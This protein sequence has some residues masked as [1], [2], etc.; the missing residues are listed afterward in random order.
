GSLALAISGPAGAQD[1]GSSLQILTIPTIT[2]SPVV[3]NVLIAGGGRWQSPNPRD[4]FALWQWWRCPN[5][6]AAGCTPINGMNSSPYY[7]AR[8]QALNRGMAVAGSGRVGGSPDALVAGPTTGPARR[9]SPPPPQPPATPE[10]V[11]TPEPTPAFE[12]AP[13]ATPT[14]V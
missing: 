4:T 14:P 7:R 13:A 5:S 8:D 10:P 2:G 6:A 11:V 3:G 9:V 12:V 1:R